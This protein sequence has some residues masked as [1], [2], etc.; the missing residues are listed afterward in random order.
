M[1]NR[2][3]LIQRRNKR[4]QG[5]PAP[6]VASTSACVS[7]AARPS[8][9]KMELLQ[10]SR[11]GTTTTAS[12]TITNPISS[13]GGGTLPSLYGCNAA[14]T[15]GNGSVSAALSAHRGGPY[16]GSNNSR[17]R[18]TVS[19][20]VTGPSLR[21]VSGWGGGG[22][23]NNNNNGS[24]IRTPFSSHNKNAAG[25]GVGG[26]LSSTPHRMPCRSNAGGGAAAPFG[27][28][29]L[30]GDEL[31]EFGIDG[32]ESASP[33]SGFAPGGYWHQMVKEETRVG[34]GEVPGPSPQHIDGL[35]GGGGIGADDE[36][37]GTG[38]RL[39]LDDD[40]AMA[41]ADAR[42]WTRG[43]SGGGIE[44]NMVRAG[45]VARR[46]IKSDPTSPTGHASVAAVFPPTGSSLS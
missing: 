30:S 27:A 9:T 11:R 40:V 6:I 12:T 29:P 2:F 33:G 18:G 42:R 34:E 43:G 26:S 8:N 5:T 41:E 32:P 38:V 4:A 14:G 17:G 3:N 46:V 31:G 13:G 23:G 24:G 16:A 22:G 15:S 44:G 20:F 45:S 28:A 1:K 10:T 19:A 7:D 37:E 39:P 36:C 35:M 25:G 21:S